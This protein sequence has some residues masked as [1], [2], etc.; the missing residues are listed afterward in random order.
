M[1]TRSAVVVQ[2]EEE[3]V[4][5]RLFS[6]SMYLALFRIAYCQLMPKYTTRG[7]VAAN[8][9]FRAEQR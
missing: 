8:F 1:R 6:S 2:L 5:G 7:F 3:K 9:C 4:E